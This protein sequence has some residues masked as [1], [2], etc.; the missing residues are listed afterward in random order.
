MPTSKAAFIG[1]AAQG[2]VSEPI[3]VRSVGEYRAA[4]GTSN[5]GMTLACGKYRFNEKEYGDIGG[6][7]RFLDLGQCNDTYSAIVLA[8]ELA[9]A[10]NIE[11]NDLPLSIVLS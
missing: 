8:V 4:F 2:P 10:F 3:T 9:K 6:I 11:V 5:R 1:R 7:P